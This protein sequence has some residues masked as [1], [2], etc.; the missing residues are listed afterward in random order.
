MLK[1]KHDKYENGIVLLPSREM[2]GRQPLAGAYRLPLCETTG[3]A[4]CLVALSVPLS[5]PSLE[6]AGTRTLKI[7][8]VPNQHMRRR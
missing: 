2:P 1:E 8:V 4:A 5:D 6:S 7:L 3:S